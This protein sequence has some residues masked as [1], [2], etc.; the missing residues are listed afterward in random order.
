MTLHTFNSMLLYDD[1]Y[2][3]KHCP[4]LPQKSRRIFLV[5]FIGGSFLPLLGEFRDLRQ[6]CYSCDHYYSQKMI[7][8]F[9]P[10]GSWA[11]CSCT[12]VSPKVG[13]GG[14]S[15]KDKVEC[16]CWD[17]DSLIGKKRGRVWKW[18]EYTKQ[19]MS[20]AH[21]QQSNAQPVHRPW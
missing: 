11:P 6:L 13:T 19:V 12:L 2:S 15:E 17:K 4:L 5:N 7:S 14:E 1:V 20:N 8:Y 21:H 9:S 16:V 18:K 10:A 3:S